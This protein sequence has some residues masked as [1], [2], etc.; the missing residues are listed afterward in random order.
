M[1][2]LTM[3]SLALIASAVA[4]P[5]FSAETLFCDRPTQAAQGAAMT[6]Y[7]TAGTHFMLTPITVKCSANVMLKGTDG[8]AAAWYTVAGNSN[9]GNNTYGA[10]TGGFTIV[11]GCAI[12]GGCTPQEVNTALSASN[13][14][15]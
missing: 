13:R 4:M 11:T 2:K 8:T 10:S 3:T 5:A 6:A 12:K 7:G 9:K 1:K 15:T 14:G